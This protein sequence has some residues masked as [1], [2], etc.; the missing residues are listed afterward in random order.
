[1]SID[2]QRKMKNAVQLHN[3]LDAEQLFDEV[4]SGAGLTS[5]DSEAAQRESGRLSAIYMNNKDKQGK[6][7]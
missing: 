7:V 2:V 3:W 6:K 1:M 5:E 4:I